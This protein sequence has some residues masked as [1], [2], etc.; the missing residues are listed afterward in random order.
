MSKL[1]NVLPKL[2]IV[3]L[4]NAPKQ[5][6]FEAFASADALAEWW[7][8][9]G[10]RVGVKSFSFVHGGKFHYWMDTE[11]QRMWGLFK[12]VTIQPH[13]LIEFISSFSDEAGAICKS[14]FPIDLPLEIF[15][16]ITLTE[17]NGRTTLTL[18][19]QPVNAT[20][21]QEAVFTSITDSMEQGFGGTFDQLDRYLQSRF[22]L[23]NKLKTDSRARV[24]TY[25]N[26]NGKTEEAFT[27]YRSVFKT[28]FAG[29]G[30]QR[31]GDIPAAAGQP[32]MSE[33][34]KKLVLHVELP[35][36]G[37][38]LLMATDAPESMGFKIAP[39]NNMHICLEPESREEASRLF[40]ALSVGGKIDMPMQ[41]MFFG[42]YFG[43]FADRFG[44]NWMINYIVK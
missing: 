17:S 32:P 31:F 3:R 36:L 21:E 38:H 33:A 20:P 23:R 41:D 37:G 11:G 19:G 27:F 42:A 10:S 26:F 1:T 28:E 12:Y 2:K 44:I 4:F 39:G 29:Q 14:P 30:I 18:Q 13:D 5:V 9:A 35:I 40:D 25:L 43:S 8:P 6:V 15:N 7:G 24:A 16:K 34:D 22:E